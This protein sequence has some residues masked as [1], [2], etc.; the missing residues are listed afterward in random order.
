MASPKVIVFGPTGGVGSAAALTAQQCGAQVVLA[1]RDTHKPIP[2]LTPEQERAGGFERVQ[3]DLTKP[4]TVQAA[5]VQTGAKR[6]FIYVAIGAPDHMRAAITAL[7]AGGVE[8]VVILSS[9]SVQGQGD[10]L[11]RYTPAEFINWQ[12]AQVELVL[13]E[14]FGTDRFATIRPGY[15]ASNFF[16][17][18]KAIAAGGTVKIP[19]PEAKF[20]YIAPEDIGRVSGTVLAGGPQAVAAAGGKHIIYLAGPQLVPQGDVLV[21]IGKALGKDLKVEGF[22]DDEEAVKFL[23][24]VQGTPEPVAKQ[25]VRGYKATAEGQDVF[26]AGTLEEAVANSEK[27]GRKPGT[28]IQDWVETNKDRFAA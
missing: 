4:E 19:Y 8:F 28:K 17:F 7:K 1:M 23:V 18:K 5:V 20:D 25:L 22:A 16:G 6:A 11:R 14:V 15:F 26:P 2:G 27:Y 9:C 12:H 24:S 13:E 10:D 3:A 21:M